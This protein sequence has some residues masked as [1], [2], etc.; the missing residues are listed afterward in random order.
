MLESIVRHICCH[1]YGQ[2]VISNAKFPKTKR[3]LDSK[4]EGTKING[5]GWQAES[6]QSTYCY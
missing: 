1:E 5:E 4:T 3:S 6:L 2:P